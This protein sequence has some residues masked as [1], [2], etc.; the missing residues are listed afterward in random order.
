[1]IQDDSTLFKM[2][3]MIEM[4][5]SLLLNKHVAGEVASLRRPPCRIRT[6]LIAGEVKLPPL[7]QP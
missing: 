6:P 5:S 1:M 7:K 2:S 3:M 4:I